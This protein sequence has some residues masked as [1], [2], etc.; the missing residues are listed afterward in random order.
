MDLGRCPWTVTF[1]ST[2]L[3]LWS[4]SSRG[5]KS[6]YGDVIFHV[7]SSQCHFHRIVLKVPIQ[8]FPEGRRHAEETVRVGVLRGTTLC[9]WYDTLR[10]RCDSGYPGGQL[11]G[12]TRVWT[13]VGLVL[14]RC[15]HL[16]GRYLEVGVGNFRRVDKGVCRTSSLFDGRMGVGYG[17]LQGLG[18]FS[19]RV[20]LPITHPCSSMITD[21]VLLSLTLFSGIEV[22]KVNNIPEVLLSVK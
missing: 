22:M 21:K 12:S 14:G 10:G 2:N 20:T 19:V 6:N 4:K 17:Y 5:K 9:R 8:Y 3:F 11:S 16:F 13:V 18:V 1:Y 15:T 7:Q